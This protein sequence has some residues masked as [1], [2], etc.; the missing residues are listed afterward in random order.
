MKKPVPYEPRVI[1]LAPDWGTLS[2]CDQDSFAC[3]DASLSCKVPSWVL[4]DVGGRATQRD[5]AHAGIVKC[6]FLPK[7]Y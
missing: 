4:L 2:F 6:F 3:V 1:R 7:D 5:S